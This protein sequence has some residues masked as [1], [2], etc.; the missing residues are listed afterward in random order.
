MSAVVGREGGS[1]KVCHHGIPTE[2]AAAVGEPCANRQR[3]AGPLADRRRVGDGYRSLHVR[4]SSRRWRPASS[5]RIP[6][7]IALVTA[8]CDI[9]VLLE[10]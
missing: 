5:E 10:S 7:R 9:D 1:R 6:C 3:G 2:A 8:H 4:L